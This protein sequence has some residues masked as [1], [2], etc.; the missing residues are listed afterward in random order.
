MAFSKKNRD[1]FYITFPITANFSHLYTSKGI[2]NDFEANGKQS[3]DREHRV[4]KVFYFFFWPLFYRTIRQK[5]LSSMKS[6]KTFCHKF[7]FYHL[8]KLSN[9]CI[10]NQF[11]SFVY[12]L[13][14]I[15]SG[16][17]LFRVGCI[18]FKTFIWNSL[19]NMFFLYSKIKLDAISIY[20][21][22]VFFLV[23]LL[24]MFLNNLSKLFLSCD[25]ICIFRARWRGR[26]VAEWR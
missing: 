15:F 7:I 17:I 6:N 24:R 22:W 20:S 26:G 3:F 2:N 14:V 8:V 1:F 12:N 21:D 13:F 25:K 10:E 16:F 23:L 5:N 4:R 9:I 19:V 11:C 18:C